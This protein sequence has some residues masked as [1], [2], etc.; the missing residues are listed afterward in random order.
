[1]EIKDKYRKIKKVCLDYCHLND[2]FSDNN[3]DNNNKK[4]ISIL[5]ILTAKTEDKFYSIKAQ[6]F[7]KWP[8]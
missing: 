5:Y 8:D 3:K 7:P 2:P 1:M 6:K 4:E